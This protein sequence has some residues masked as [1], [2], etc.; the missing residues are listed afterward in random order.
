MLMV[1]VRDIDATLAR[2]KQLGAPVVTTG[3][4]PVSIDGG[5][6][7]GGRGAGSGRALRRARAD[8]ADRRRR[9]RARMRIS[10]A[11]EC[12][13]RSRTSSARSRFIV[14]RSGCKARAEVPQ[15]QAEPS[16]LAL[17]GLPPSAQYRFTTL[18]VPT[19]GLLIELIEFKGARRPAAPARIQ[20]PGSTRI[21]LRVSDIDAAVAALTQAGGTFMSTGGQAARS[22]RGQHDAEGRHRARSRR[23][24]HRAHSGA[25]RAAVTLVEI[26][27]LALTETRGRIVPR[28]RGRTRCRQASNRGD[29]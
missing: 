3:G 19:S 25:A 14:T 15:Y 28:S 6:L 22:T 7:R 2:L 12:G 29:S 21:Q 13:T 24:V 17:L 23:P 26:L 4:A 11:S 10:S 20:D 18:T 8:R 16:V 5:P 9:R 27:D 1:M